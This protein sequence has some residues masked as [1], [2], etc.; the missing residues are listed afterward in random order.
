MMIWGKLI[1]TILG[2]MVAQIPGAVVGFILGY[3]FDEGLKQQSLISNLFSSSDNRAKIQSTFFKATFTLMGHVAKSDGVISQDEVKNVEKIMQQLHIDSQARKQAI[4]Y[5]NQGKSASFNLEEMLAEFVLVCKKQ[6]ALLQ[7]FIEIQLQAAYLDG[8]LVDSKRAILIFVSERLGIDRT[9]FARLNAMHQAEDKFREYM[10]Q[11]YQHKFQK[12][13][14]TSTVAE[15]YKILSVDP[16]A[17][18]AVVK[19]AYRKLMSLHHPDKL[20][21]QGLPEEMIKLTT[22]KTVEIQKAYETIVEAREKSSS[23]T[24]P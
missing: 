9:L 10:H 3:F 16:S 7:I 15:A 18:D 8:V 22:E 20:I 19:K 11:Q 12:M 21:A 13:R 14:N 6:K 24:Y 23:R 2:Y 4:E 5:F 17:S 1:G